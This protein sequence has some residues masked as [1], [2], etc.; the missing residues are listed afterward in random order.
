M[1][2]FAINL[3]LTFTSASFTIISF[4]LLCCLQSASWSDTA[5]GQLQAGHATA[6][7]QPVFARIDDTLPLVT[8][9]AAAAKVAEVVKV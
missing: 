6:T 5:W 2:A 4:F 9:P 7:P 3:V 1:H 8:Q